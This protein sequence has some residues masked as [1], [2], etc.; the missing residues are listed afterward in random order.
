MASELVQRALSGDRRALA[1]I[2]TLIER[3]TDSLADVMKAVHGHGEPAYCIGITGP[4]GAG[5]STIVDWLVQI[6]RDGN[7]AVGVLA[8]DPTSPFTGGALLGD[9]VRMRRHYLDREVFIRSLAT[10]GARGGLSGVTAASVKLLGACGK[11]VVIVETVGV[12][13]TELEIM[14]VADTV[15]VTLVPE[16]G[17]AVQTM[18][19]GLT[20]IADIFVVNKADREGAQR[21]AASLQA[22][23]ELGG[24]HGPWRPPVLLTQA[25]RG[26]GLEAL[27][28][29]VLE[30]RRA[31]E[32]SSELERRRRERRRHEFTKAVRDALEMDI[33]TMIAQGGPLAEM[34]SKVQR[35]EIDPFSAASTLLED[36]ELLSQLAR[37]ASSGRTG[38]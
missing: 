4:P 9:R 18:K 32:E 23:L 34:A 6:F 19:A 3:D 2:F 22:S 17:D 24:D 13:Q 36:G 15:V 27:H 1:R 37:R 7:T 10:R 29:T 25:H 20:E 30:H 26:E 5:K 31:L 12:G 21:L 33:E 16:A 28:D 11:D 38:K 35:D 14:K 8:V